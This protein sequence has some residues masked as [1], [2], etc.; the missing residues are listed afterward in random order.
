MSK[1]Y[2]KP[3]TLLKVVNLLERK[4]ILCYE[5]FKGGKII[6]ESVFLILG[7]CDDISTLNIPSV[8][9]YQWFN[10]YHLIL[11][12]YYTYDEEIAAVSRR[13]FQSF[14]VSSKLFLFFKFSK[15]SYMSSSGGL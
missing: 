11:N 9:L 6:L 3:E 7:M 12:I 5:K 4:I 14:P 1:K 10:L 15:S 13:K 8:T 2:T